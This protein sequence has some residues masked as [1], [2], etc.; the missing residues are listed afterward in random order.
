MLKVAVLI[1]FY[2]RAAYLRSAIDSALAQTLTYFERP[3]IGDSS[4]AGSATR[5]AGKRLGTQTRSAFE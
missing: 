2:N 1:P 3:V 5:L 4:T